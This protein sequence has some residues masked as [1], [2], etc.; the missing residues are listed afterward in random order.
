ML[1]GQARHCT[2]N[3][4]VEGLATGGDGDR[5]QHGN[6][7]FDELAAGE[8]ATSTGTPA[9]VLPGFSLAPLTR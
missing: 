5:D 6:S 8:S 9:E 3:I 1:D 7:T 2:D 4:P